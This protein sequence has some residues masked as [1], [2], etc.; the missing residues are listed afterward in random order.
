MFCGLVV[1][2]VF[3]NTVFPAITISSS[4]SQR[5]IACSEGDLLFRAHAQN[6]MRAWWLTYNGAVVLV[7]LDRGVAEPALRYSLGNSEPW[8]PALVVGIMQP[9]L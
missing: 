6:L 7:D 9:P 3:T 5:G 1:K 2:P 4:A 8:F